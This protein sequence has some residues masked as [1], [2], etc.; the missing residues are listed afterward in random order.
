MKTLNKPNT[1]KNPLR[2]LIGLWAV[3]AL[4]CA[5]LLTIAGV[6]SAD[7]GQGAVYQIALT[8]N[9]NGP[10]PNTADYWMNRAFSAR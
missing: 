10:P 8:S 2:R 9:L 3:A 1:N 6:A 4:A 5:L 7:Y